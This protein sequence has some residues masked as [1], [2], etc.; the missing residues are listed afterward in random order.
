LRGLAIKKSKGGKTPIPS[1][2]LKDKGFLREVKILLDSCSL[3]PETVRRARE[4]ALEIVGPCE[5][6]RTGGLEVAPMRCCK[7][8]KEAWA[9]KSTH[10]AIVIRDQ[11]DVQKAGAREHVSECPVTE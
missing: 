1:M 5:K 7:S 2:L 9:G 10:V 3:D 11:H 6:A 4:A 8:L